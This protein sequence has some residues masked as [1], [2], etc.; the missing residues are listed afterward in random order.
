MKKN[1]RDKLRCPFCFNLS[2][3]HSKSNKSIRYKCKLCNKTYTLNENTEIKV[4]NL[5]KVKEILYNR[6]FEFENLYLKLKTE[7]DNIKKII[8]YLERKFTNINIDKDKKKFFL[9]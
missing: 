1:K 7:K 5:E 3:F 4:D 6:I 9:S 2:M 8:N